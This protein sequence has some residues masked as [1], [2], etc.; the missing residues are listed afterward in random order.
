MFHDGLE[1]QITEAVVLF[2]GKAILFFGWWSLK[3][4]LPLGDARDVRFNLTGPVN[5]AGRNLQVVVTVSIIQE[6]HWSI[7]DA[8]VKMR[9]KARGQDI[10]VEQQK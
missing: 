2:S 8:V 4:G 1:E 5:L 7:A 9:F 10:P 3:E 6:S